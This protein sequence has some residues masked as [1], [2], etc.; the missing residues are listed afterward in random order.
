MLQQ[1]IR[2]HKL[3]CLKSWQ[4]SIHGDIYD[5][6]VDMWSLAPESAKRKSVGKIKLSKRK[7]SGKVRG[8]CVGTR[9]PQVDPCSHLL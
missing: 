1:I 8:L 2:L 7:E 6:T 3:F 9:R 5:F 4:R